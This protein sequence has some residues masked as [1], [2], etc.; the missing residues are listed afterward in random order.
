MSVGC[1]YLALL[2][3]GAFQRRSP[4][5]DVCNAARWIVRAG[6]PRLSLIAWIHTAL[7]ATAF[8]PWNAKRQETRS[9][10]PVTWTTGHLTRGGSGH[11]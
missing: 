10:L 3:E 6:A 1:P 7:G 8:A 11:Q 5:R 4:L 2:P 9:C